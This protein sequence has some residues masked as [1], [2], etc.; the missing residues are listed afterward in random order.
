MTVASELKAKIR[1]FVLNYFVKE[2]GLVLDDD[3][4]FLEKGIIDS[5]GVLELA[6]F[7]EVTFGFKVEDEEIIPDTFDSVNKL[8][9][10]VQSKLTTKPQVSSLDP[11]N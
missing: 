4:S 10:Y 3:T 9:N 8:V 5:T 11:G 2:S 7:L 1:E 6:A